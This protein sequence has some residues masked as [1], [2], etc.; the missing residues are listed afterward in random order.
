MSSIPHPFSFDPTYGYSPDQ[1]LSITHAD[2]EPS[3]FVDF[4]RELKEK[5]DHT[6]LEI[7]T[8]EVPSPDPAFRL[9]KVYYT[10]YPDYRVGAWM[11]CPTDSAGI[12][13]GIVCGHGY[14]GRDEPEWDQAALDR[15]VIFPVAPG[16]QISANSQLPIN[17]SS[18]HVIHGIDDKETYVL[19]PCACAF[20]RAID[21][22]EAV[23][24]RPLEKFHYCGW[25]FGGGIGALML[26]WEPRF[27]SAELGQPTFGN[28]P[29]RLR[30][31]CVG[32]GE[33][34]RQL[35]ASRPQIARTL[36]FFD[37]AIAARYLKIP[38]VFACATFDPAVPPPGQFSVANAHPGPKRLSIFLTGHFDDA[39][40]GAPYEERLHRENL[41]ELIGPAA[42]PDQ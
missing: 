29:V 38:V 2:S 17:D 18:R 36:A 39:H 1:L 25:S 42:C 22:L 4:W 19:G 6:P 26:P 21:V 30:S 32:S 28:H 15:I 9:M 13:F 10:V 7:S 41:R 11:I 16:F 5:S 20:W 8:E 35:H 27:T 14:G 33:A 37:A 34:V 23:S 31:E 24:P 12:R 40:A 3:G